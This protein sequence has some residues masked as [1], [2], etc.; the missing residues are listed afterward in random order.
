[1]WLWLCSFLCYLKLCLGLAEEIIL[2][3]GTPNST[4][5][6]LPL[7]VDIF[8]RINELN[9]VISSLNLTVI[10]FPIYLFKSNMLGFLLFI[11]NYFLWLFFFIF[12]RNAIQ[13]L[14]L[15]LFLLRFYFLIFTILKQCRIEDFWRALLIYNLLLLFLFFPY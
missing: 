9:N 8:G 13:N 3:E 4:F 12:E 15:L 11:F 7:I 14:Y 10:T 5:L 1:M 6:S 2:F